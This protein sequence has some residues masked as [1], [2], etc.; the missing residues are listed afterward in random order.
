MQNI[1]NLSGLLYCKRVK[2]ELC[3]AVACFPQGGTKHLEDFRLLEKYSFNPFLVY[4][5]KTYQ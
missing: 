5:G 3:H 1:S 2:S 4:L